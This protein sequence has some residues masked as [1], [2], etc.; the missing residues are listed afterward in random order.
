M[1]SHAGC[2]ALPA[3]QSRRRAPD[4]A[5]TEQAG[6]NM[7]A[8]WAAGWGSCRAG[9]KWARCNVPEDPVPVGRGTA[10]CWRSQSHLAHDIHVSLATLFTRPNQGH[11]SVSP[12][13]EAAWMTLFG[14]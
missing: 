7:L 4:G 6:W 10:G 1:L 9:S 13:K 3:F 5:C 8:G 12:G 11:V 14:G 2:N